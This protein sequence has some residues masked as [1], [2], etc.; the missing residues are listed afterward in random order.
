MPTADRM[1]LDSGFVRGQFPALEDEWTFLDNA[2]GSQILEPVLR[3]IREYLVTSNVQH[4]ASYDVSALAMDRVAEATAAMA[5]FVNASPAEIVMGPSTT[6]LLHNLALCLGRTLA[7]GD[8]VIVTDCDHEANI[9]AWRR[10]E[11]RGVRVR[12]WKVRPESW[13]LELDDLRALLTDRTRWVALT[14]ASNVIGTIHPVREISRVV[15]DAGAMVCVD[16]VAFAP[17]RRIDVRDLDVDFYA[18]SFY[19]VYGPHY[20]ML[21]GK[22][23]HL[24]RLP[25]INHFF[26][27]PG[28][29]PYKFQPGGVNYELCHGMLGLEDY[30][31]D[32]ASVHRQGDT[33]SAEPVELMFDLVARHEEK[34]AARLLDFLN[35]KPRARVIGLPESDRRKRVPTV[36]FVVDGVPSDE[37]SRRIDDHRIGIRHGDFYA[38]RLAEA[39][40]YAPESGF[41]RVSMVHYNTLPEID[42]LIRGL[43]PLF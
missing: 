6:Q 34:L 4:G 41:V 30:A 24:L 13:S 15:H 40:G 16:G 38:R 27:G 8:E 7:E 9:G 2:G 39:L 12:T 10:L 17:H 14:H 1:D 33:A 32:F 22:Q 31:R 28:Q 36:S 19:K 21:Y 43:D 18:L 11:E 5:G 37:I 29:V 25:G 35:G 26:I 20:A 23:E 3:R 42:A